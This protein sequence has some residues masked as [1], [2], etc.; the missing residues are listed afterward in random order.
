MKGLIKKTMIA[1]CGV[2]A[3]I[4]AGCL[5]YKCVDPCYPQRY[6]F[7]ARQEV[8]AAMAPQVQNGH[9]LDQTIWNY[10][11]EQGTDKLTTGGLERLA[12][13]A[14]RRPCPDT[15]LY[16]QTAQDVVYDQNVPEKMAETRQTLDGKRIAAVQAYLTAQTAG[17]PT[18]FQIYIHDPAEP[19][20]AATPVNSAVSKMYL[21]FQGGLMMGGMGG[22]GMGGMGGMMGGNI[23]STGG[24]NVTG[25]SGTG[26]GR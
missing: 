4:G 26:T 25:G 16:L 2:A 3:V 17:R 1:V 7:L 18:Q 23:G 11:F 24:A 13:L 21:R 5:P 12:N 20:L 14:R 19:S 9:V 15:V 22:M 10:Y 6:N 8:N